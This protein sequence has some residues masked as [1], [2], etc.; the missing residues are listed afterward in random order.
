MSA[1][2]PF[3]VL[4]IAAIFG[5]WAGVAGAQTVPTA[6][7]ATP[8][9]AGPGA[10]AQAPGVPG[11][12]QGGRGFAPVVI[13]PPAPVPPQVAIPRPSA[14]ELAQIN[15]ALANSGQTISPAPP[16][17]LP[18]NRIALPELV[19]EM[20]RGAIELL[21]QHRNVSH[22]LCGHSHLPQRHWESGVEIIARPPGKELQSISLMSGGEKTLTCVAL[23]LAIFRS[24]PSPFCVLDE[25]DAPLDDAN[26]TRFTELLTELSKETQFVVITHNKRTMEI[27]QTLY[28]V[29][30]EEPGVSKIVGVDFRRQALAS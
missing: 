4:V 7:P 3:R 23:L 18:P 2:G 1:K 6:P 17:E 9:G 29:T 20:Q 15:E 28:G 27:A 12:A 14:A 13:G 24:R 19:G 26:I 8:P 30:M 11:R 21:L 22:I 16:I 5:G 10:P 25:V